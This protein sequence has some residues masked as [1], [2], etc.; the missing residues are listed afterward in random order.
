[1]QHCAQPDCRHSS[2][3]RKSDSKFDAVSGHWINCKCHWVNVSKTVFYLGSFCFTCA[4]SS[5]NFLNSGAIIWNKT[6]KVLQV[7][8]A[9]KFESE[10]KRLWIENF[11]LWTLAIS[12]ARSWEIFPD[13]LSLLYSGT[14]NT[15][16][17]L[18]Q[19]LQLWQGILYTKSINQILE[20]VDLLG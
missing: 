6:Q 4:F 16:E 2:M 7:Q 5:F 12:F 3:Y 11:S 19:L 1:M 13:Y 14:F 10:L 18:L 9:R 17:R 8:P 20:T 15:F